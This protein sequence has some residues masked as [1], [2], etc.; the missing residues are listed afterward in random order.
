MSWPENLRAQIIGDFVEVARTRGCAQH[1]PDDAEAEARRELV[2]A[3]QRPPSTQP[4]RRRI[5]TR[6]DD[7]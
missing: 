3:P 1:S 5:V 6:K 7:V 4:R 2:D